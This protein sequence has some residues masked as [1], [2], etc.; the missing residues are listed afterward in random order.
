MNN[1]YYVSLPYIFRDL[2]LGRLLFKGTIDMK[3]YKGCF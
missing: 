2:G 3:S 1:N